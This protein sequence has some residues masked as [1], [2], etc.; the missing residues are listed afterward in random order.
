MK[1]GGVISASSEKNCDTEQY[2]LLSVSKAHKSPLKYSAA[3]YLQALLLLMQP[4]Q[5]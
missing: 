3:K 1:S 2:L 5:I 4:L